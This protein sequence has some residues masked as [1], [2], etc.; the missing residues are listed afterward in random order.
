MPPSGSRVVDACRS[1]ATLDEPVKRLLA[2]GLRERRFAD[3]D[4]IL[5]QGHPGMGLFLVAEGQTAVVLRDDQGQRRELARLGLGEVFGE[6]SLLTKE[7]CTADVVAAGP[8]VAFHLGIEEFERLARKHPELGIVL[9]YLIGERLGEE[10]VDG[11]G[12][13]TL[14]RYH[15]ERCV[16]R[17]AMAVVYEAREADGE[18]PVA[19][20]MMSHRLVYES[21]AMQR[22]QAE[23]DTLLSLG[24]E[25][26]SRLHRRFDAFSTCFLAMEYCD[27]SDLA[28]VIEQR[29]ALPEAEVRKIAGHLAAALLHLHGRGIVHRDL[30]PSNVMTTQ[31]G[32]IKLTDFGLATAACRPDD[33]ED[34]EARSALLGTPLYMSPEQLEGAP[35]APASDLYA[36]GCVLYELASGKRAF[37]ASSL[38]QLIALKHDFRLPAAR[39]LGAGVSWRLHRLLKRLLSTDPED[40]LVPLDKYAAWAEPLAP[41][42]ASS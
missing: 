31:R 21:G 29:G 6:M 33:I 22:F 4:V 17:G 25:N 36:L 13:K 26:I 24:H 3:G 9:T 5:T 23:A 12:G 10:S 40:R 37:S 30:K 28:Q 42:L 11:L 34:T 27:G 35:P 18:R 41:D 2:R 14:D 1:L 8:V 7:P 20:K 38:M 19:L 39:N 16:G 15:I 32:E